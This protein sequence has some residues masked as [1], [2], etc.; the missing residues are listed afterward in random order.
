MTDK[1]LYTIEVD[2]CETCPGSIREQKG[3][4]RC[5]HDTT[6]EFRQNVDMGVPAMCPMRKRL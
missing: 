3:V 5:R 2:S 4:Y 1:I 6:I